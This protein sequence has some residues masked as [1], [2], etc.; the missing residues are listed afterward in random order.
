MKRIKIN[1]IPLGYKT[2]E[3]IKKLAENLKKN[4]YKMLHGLDDVDNI[5]EHIVAVVVDNHDKVMFQSSVT[6]MACWCS[7]YKAR[8]L[9]ISMALDN[10]DKLFI[11][12]D[13]KLYRKLL[14]ERRKNG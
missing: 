14:N 2:K 8:P 9:S 12:Q 11:E 13:E 4:G 6:C 3:E 5:K 7:T 1:Q 10:F